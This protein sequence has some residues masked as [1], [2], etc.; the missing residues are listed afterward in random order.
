MDAIASV[1]IGGTSMAGGVG[2][3]AGT[4]FGVLILGILNNMFNLLNLN[5]YVQDVVK[6]LIILGAV[7]ATTKNE[8]K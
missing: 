2:G 8:K 7:F 6:G 3:I 4:F 5:A 1:A